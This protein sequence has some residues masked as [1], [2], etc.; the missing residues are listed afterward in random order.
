MTLQIDSSSFHSLLNNQAGIG[1]YSKNIVKNINQ[2][3]TTPSRS[4]ALHITRAHNANRKAVSLEDRLYESRA[5]C[6][7]KMAEV[8]MYLP[9]D[10][11]SRFF[12][13]L[14]NLMDIDN[15]EE[16]DSPITAASFTTLLRMLLLIWPVRRPGLGATS[17][18]H[19]IATW[20]A[21][22]DRLTIECLPKDNVRWVLSRY[23]EGNRE[24]AAGEISVT[25]LLAVLSP[26]DPKCWF[27]DGP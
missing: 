26:Y 9:S 6:K 25:R 3:L 13:Q 20:T 14:D 10:W 8:A 12:S 19:I 15:W 21:E 17:K 2:S 4:G 11:R 22:N 1:Q 27:A 23:I 5:F 16:D 24:S 7:T 18:G